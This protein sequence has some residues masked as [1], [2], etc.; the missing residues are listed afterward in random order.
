MVN[1]RIKKK[2]SLTSRTVKQIYWCLKKI[3]GTYAGLS[4]PIFL[5]CFVWF[6]ASIKK[7][8]YSEVIYLTKA[9]TWGIRGWIITPPIFTTHVSSSG[10]QIIDTDWWTNHI[11]ESV[12]FHKWSANAGEW[13]GRVLVAGVFS[14][15]LECQEVERITL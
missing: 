4:L 2:Y 1:S 14:M 15:S 7:S 13:F 6:L 10:S 5:F 8:E 12:V 11:L 3:V 9:I